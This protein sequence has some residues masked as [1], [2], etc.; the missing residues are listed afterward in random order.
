VTVQRAPL[1][2]PPP[3]V[4]QQQFA[5]IMAHTFKALHLAGRR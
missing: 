2:H 5:D 3:G 1:L 4:T